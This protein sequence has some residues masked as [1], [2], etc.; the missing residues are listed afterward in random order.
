MEILIPGAH[1]R[2]ART[3]CCACA[4]EAASA[5]PSS[6]LPNSRRS[7]CSF[8][9][10]QYISAVLYCGHVLQNNAHRRRVRLSGGGPGPEAAIRDDP[11]PQR[12]ELDRRT[13]R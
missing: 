4:V 3:F 9:E 5:V 13:D 12:T 6:A 1:G 7:K 2:L 11:L 8:I 10:R